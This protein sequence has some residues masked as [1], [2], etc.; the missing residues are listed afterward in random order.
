MSDKKQTSKSVM[1]EIEKA[2][3]AYEKCVEKQ[4]NL[5]AEISELGKRIKELEKQYDVLYR[6]EL[7]NKIAAAWFK[8]GKMTD[9]QILKFL[10]LSE[11][12]R[13]KIDILDTEKAVKAIID[14]CGDGQKVITNDNFSAVK[15]A[16][17]EKETVGV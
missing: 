17:E 9:A 15:G 12:I 1:S 4:K 16:K 14:A 13:D 5:K 6:E 10:E 8:D 11:G 3:K 2:K 7:K